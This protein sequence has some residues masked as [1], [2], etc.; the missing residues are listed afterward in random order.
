MRRSSC[1]TDR[2]VFFLSGKIEKKS[3]VL[4]TFYVLLMWK[5]IMCGSGFFRWNQHDG[6][7]SWKTLSNIQQDYL[8]SSNN[9]Y[10]GK[11]A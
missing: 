11:D 10:N 3:N 1:K 6:K 2:S 5:K 4:D 8:F 7:E 9:L